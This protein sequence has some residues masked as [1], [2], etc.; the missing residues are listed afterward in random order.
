MSA[1]FLSVASATAF[2]SFIWS[3]IKKNPLK[4][5][6]LPNKIIICRYLKDWALESEKMRKSFDCVSRDQK[7]V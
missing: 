2:Q 5:D 3:Q 4:I 1:K 6:T 7:C